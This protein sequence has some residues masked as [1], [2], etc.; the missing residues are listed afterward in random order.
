MLGAAAPASEAPRL[1]SRTIG[2]ATVGIGM[3]CDTAE[4][5]EHYAALRA[6]GEEINPAAAKVNAEAKN[7]GACGIAAVAYV[8]DQTMSTKSAGDNLLKVVR[9]NVVAGYDGSGWQRVSNMVQY[10]VIE[11]E[12]LSI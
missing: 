12:G 3:I 9:I 7:P 6:D 4:Q 2:G 10:A 1:S 5:A 8:P 11:T